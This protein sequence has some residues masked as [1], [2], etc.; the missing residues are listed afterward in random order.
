MTKNTFLAPMPVALGE[1]IFS[2]NNPTTK[3]PRENL[4]FQGYFHLPNLPMIIYWNTWQNESVVHGVH[5]ELTI[6]SQIPSKD[7][8]AR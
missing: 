2:K 7:V 5:R 3:I 4:N 8:R 6:P 1:I